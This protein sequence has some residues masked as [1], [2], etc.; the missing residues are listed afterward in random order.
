MP[1]LLTAIPVL[2]ALAACAPAAKAPRA[3]FT[4]LISSGTLWHHPPDQTSTMWPKC[5]DAGC[6]SFYSDDFPFTPAFTVLQGP[7]IPIK[8]V[9]FRHDVALF[10]NDLTHFP[11]PLI[12]FVGRGDNASFG[13]IQAPPN[14]GKHQ[15]VVVALAAGQTR[16]PD[17]SRPAD[18]T[19]TGAATIRT[20]DSQTYTGDV[21][22]TVITKTNVV[23]VR[24]HDLTG[25]DGAT[26]PDYLW[27]NLSHFRAAHSLLSTPTQTFLRGSLHGPD[28][29]TMMFVFN[30]PDR[31]LVGAA[32]ALRDDSP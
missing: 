12:R 8:Q 21:A 22:V 13:V 18:G 28:H 1:R 19:W 15:G 4:T 6:V 27:R 5:E 23:R 3:P 24:I 11:N 10:R 14:P 2:L 9:T 17:G 16:P 26:L 25:P 29:E 20:L 30:D 32:I 31:R 7:P